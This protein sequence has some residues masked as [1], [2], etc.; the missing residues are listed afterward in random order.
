MTI[1]QS[2]M[3][4][5]G[6]IVTFATGTVKPIIQDVF[7]FIHGYGAAHYFADLYGSADDSQHNFQ[8]WQCGYERVCRSLAAPFQ[9]AMPIIQRHYYRDYDH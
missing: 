1:L 2:I 7:T 3:G 5:V 6:Q 8:Y 4:V 9:V